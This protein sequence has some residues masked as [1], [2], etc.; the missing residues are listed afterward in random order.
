MISHVVSPLLLLALSA[1]VP[2]IAVAGV[3]PV[4]IFLAPLVGGLLTSFAAECELAVGGT[5]LVWF[6]II[7]ILV[8][9]V[10]LVVRFALRQP[11]DWKG[12]PRLT[13]RLLNID[14][15]WRTPW[16]WITAIVVAGRLLGHCERYR[17]R[18]LSMTRE[19]FGRC[20]HCLSTAD[21]TRT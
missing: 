4:T 3:R 10:S 14:K 7:A 18:S 6:I 15:E 16:P 21:I 13:A 8:N 19:L 20:I 5:L 2:S 12:Q 11:G 17:C 9:L 1:L